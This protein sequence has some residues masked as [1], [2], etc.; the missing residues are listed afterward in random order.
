[1]CLFTTVVSGVASG[2]RLASCGGGFLTGFQCS[3]HSEVWCAV[4]HKISRNPARHQSR[5]RADQELKTLS[6]DTNHFRL[7]RFCLRNEH[8]YAAVDQ[9]D[10]SETDEAAAG[11]S[12]TYA[13]VM[14]KKKAKKNNGADAELGMNDVTYAE[15]QLKPMKK[16]KKAQG[17]SEFMD[18]DLVQQLKIKT[19]PLPGMLGN[20][21]T[22]YY[23]QG[24]RNGKPDGLSRVFPVEKGD[25]ISKPILPTSVT[26]PALDLDLEARDKP[27]TVD[28]PGTTVYQL[29]VQSV[30]ESVT[31][32]LR[33]TESPS[34]SQ[35]CGDTLS[36]G[37]EGESS[38]PAHVR[39]GPEQTAQVDVEVGM[40]LPTSGDADHP[41]TGGANFPALAASGAVFPDASGSESDRA[42][43]AMSNNNIP[44]G[45]L[46][47]VLSTETKPVCGEEVINTGCTGCTV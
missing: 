28:K 29:N 15:I 17:D 18:Q 31:S 5:I 1:M 8:L 3:V 39:D 47:E 12:D 38:A 11:S 35:F 7:V 21:F 13:Q 30:E 33:V 36:S 37:E 43:A 20:F 6:Q 44:V 46:P 10:T 34:D 42:A 9:A 24:S 45:K 19:E 14:K 16:E 22:L 23:R 4:V 32:Q 40:V 27:A 26:M 25:P 2:S 41:A